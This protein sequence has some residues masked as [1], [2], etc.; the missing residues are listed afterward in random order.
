MCAFVAYPHLG[1]WP[2]EPSCSP[3]TCSEIAV[4]T[5][6]FTAGAVCPGGVASGGPTCLFNCETGYELTTTVGSNTIACGA[7]GELRGGRVRAG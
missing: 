3:I 4:A 1:V 2:A 5:S 6:T 7:D